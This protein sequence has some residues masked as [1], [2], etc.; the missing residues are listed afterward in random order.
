MIHLMAF[1]TKDNRLI[2][3]IEHQATIN[4]NMLFQEY[5]MEDMKKMF[6]EEAREAGRE[7]GKEE[8]ILLSK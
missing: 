5:T 1:L 3:L 2:V 6:M 8:G 4:P 7:E